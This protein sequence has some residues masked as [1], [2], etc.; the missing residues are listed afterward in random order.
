[1]ADIRDVN[2]NR[3]AIF[4]AVVEA[5]SFTAA[6]VR[7]GLTKTMV[8]THLQRLEREIGAGLLVRTTRRLSVTESGRTFYEASCKILQATEEALSAVSGESAPLRGT[9]RVSAP[10][11][12]GSLVVAPALVEMRSAYPELDIELVCNDHYVDL[13]AEGIDVA[14]RLG[15]LADSGYRVVKIG[16]FV[17]WVVASPAFI[18]TWGKPKTPAALAAMPHVALSVL[19]HPLTL[20]LQREKGA[21]QSVR[22]ENA[23]LVNAADAARA[24]TLAGG[25]FGLLTD[26]SISAD[27]AARRLVRLLPDWSGKPKGIHAVFPPTR[28]PTAKVRALIEVIRRRLESQVSG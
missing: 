23:M 13:I 19:P 16:G 5:G 28:Y 12:Y 17:K 11:D 25:G 18:D 6:A 9:L 22:C 7:L 10:I 2:L 24:A 8:S 27:V 26:F 3:L 20:D 1:M 15:Q 4:V 21:K 14:I